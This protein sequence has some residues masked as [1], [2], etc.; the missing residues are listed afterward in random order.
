MHALLPS[1]KKLSKLIENHRADQW[2]DTLDKIGD[3]KKNSHPLWNTIHYLSGKKSPAQPNTVIT[4][5]NKPA[6]T[7]QQKANAFNKQFVNTI[8]HA[9]KNTNRKID[10]HTK[11]L[12]PTPIQITS[13]Q[14]SEAINASSNNNST[15]PDHINIRHLKHL[16]P[17]A[18]KYL[19]DL[20]NLALNLNI[21]PQI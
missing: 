8:K 16:G 9:T 10:K 12:T 11:A 3:H 2:R 1:T 15:G 17:L 4:F 14:V 13:M 6:I 7:P 18:I 5:K 20:L 21:I 19:T